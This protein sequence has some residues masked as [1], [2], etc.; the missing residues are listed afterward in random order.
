MIN[1]EKINSEHTRIKN[2]NK[3]HQN[4]RDDLASTLRNSKKII[5]QEKEQIKEKT[6]ELKAKLMQYIENDDY[7]S[8]G[9][10]LKDIQS[11]QE[12]ITER[13]N[14][15]QFI[16]GIKEEVLSGN[17]GEKFIKY[18]RHRHRQDKPDDFKFRFKET[19]FLPIEN[20]DI[21]SKDEKEHIAKQILLDHSIM[22][23]I[24]YFGN[25]D[26]NWRSALEFFKAM[27]FDIKEHGKL[28]TEVMSSWLHDK[29]SIPHYVF[30]YIQEVIST[31]PED[32]FLDTS[33][34]MDL[35]NWQH[36]YVKWSIYWKN[37]NK[38]SPEDLKNIL[39]KNPTLKARTGGGFWGQKYIHSIVLTI[40]A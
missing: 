5:P 19:I 12:S 18:M 40:S 28:A 20:L 15:E 29:K 10:V 27:N 31:N 34:L 11:V 30:D 1:Q 13:Q 22:P 2:R 36:N 25:S 32:F 37:G 14:K 9:Q 21:F 23:Q 4:F 17:Y 16:R 35:A 26:Q 38:I 24:A 3:V 7:V 33:F 8:A 6:K 39:E